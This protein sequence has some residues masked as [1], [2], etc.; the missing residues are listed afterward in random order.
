M[1]PA[2][3]HDDAT[4]GRLNS[5]RYAPE[6]LL[7]PPSLM[8]G[9]NI[10]CPVPYSLCDVLHQTPSDINE[11]TRMSLWR[12]PN[13]KAVIL[14]SRQVGNSGL[15]EEVAKLG[16]LGINSLEIGRGGRG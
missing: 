1:L 10:S 15:S 14:G 6:P 4:E 5:W 9:L 8:P 12:G 13:G 16:S 11:D 7:P 2:D 3:L